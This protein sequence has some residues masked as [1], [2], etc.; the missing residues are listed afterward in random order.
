LDFRCAVEIDRASEVQGCHE[1]ADHS[2]KLLE[3]LEGQ[4]PDRRKVGDH[5]QE[6]WG[7]LE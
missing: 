4:H 3:V 7:W 1:E 6:G 5:W 2:A